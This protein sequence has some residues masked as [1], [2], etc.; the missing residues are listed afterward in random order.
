MRA[1]LLKVVRSVAGVALLASGMGVVGGL[2]IDL[3]TSGVA[4]ASGGPIDSYDLSCQAP[5]VGSLSLPVTIQDL[6]TAPA[7]VPQHTTY[8]AKPQLKVT[9]PGSLIKVA[10]EEHLTSI[11]VTAGTLTLQLLGFTTDHSVKATVSNVPL[12]VPV[13]ATTV[14]HG[15]A[16]TATFAT[17]PLTVTASVGTHAMARPANFTLTVLGLPI[18]C[19][20]PG[21]SPVTTTPATFPY[22]GTSTATPIV[23]I[24]ASGAPLKITTTSLPNGMQTTP[25]AQTVT[26]SGGATPYAWSA[27]GL[28]T[29]LSINPT[30]GQIHGTPTVD[31]TFTPVIKVTGHTGN[32][33]TKT[34]QLKITPAGLAIT[35]TSLPGG[36]ET[37]AY[38]ATVAAKGG[39]TPYAWSA[40][41]LPTGLTINA[42][43]GK[44]TGTPTESGT[45]TPVIKVTG[46]TATHVT[47]TLQI[48]IGPKLAITTT[49]LPNGTQTSAYAQSVTATGG[50]T[51]YSW[52]ATGLPTGLSINPTSGQIH[53]TPTV[54]GTF[55]PVI[56]VTG[57]TGNHVTKTLQLTITPAPLA[58]T[59]ASL[60]SGVQTIAYSA[61][62]TATGGTTPY[63]WS[64]T[65]LPTGLTIDATTGAITGTPT[66][67][68]TFTVT[69][70]V[71]GHTAMHVTKTLKLTVAPPLA[72]TTT[73]LPNGA[74]TAAYSATV[75]A[76]G[77]K[78]PYSWSA[79]GLPSGLSIGASTGKITGSPKAHGTFTVTVKVTGATATHVTKALK[80]KVTLAPLA[81]ATT[82]LPNGTVTSAY[83][84]TVTATGGT[85]P[86][87]W[88][89]TGL[90][91]GLSI[92][93]STGKITGT[94]TVAGTST[95]TVKVTGTTGN[96]VT[97]TLS[98][99]DRHSG[100]GRLRP[101]RLRRWG[102][103]LPRRAR[104]AGFFGSLPGAARRPGQ[105]R[106]SAWFPRSPTRATSSSGPT[107]GSSPSGQLRSWVRSRARGSPRPL[108]S[109]ASWPRTQ[110]RATSSWARTAGVFAFGTVPFLGSL[111]G[112][113]RRPTTSSGSPRRPRATATGWSR[114]QAPSTASAPRQA[115]GDSYGHVLAGRRPSL[116][117][118]QAAATG[119]PP[120]T[121]P[122]YP[123]GNAEVLRHTPGPPCDSRRC[124]SSASCT[125]RH[126]GLLAHRLGRRHL[127]LR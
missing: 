87:T 43:T 64:A 82:S 122:C 66:V 29:G 48:K 124:R 103:R 49:S 30:T 21:Q 58:I 116:G 11:T 71:T 74:E 22:T 106:S 104:A 90:P 61:T 69:I 107:A 78:T 109:P 28:P 100:R 20:S 45:F 55:T 98:L 111:P 85:T 97:K 96:H 63:T 56:K 62:V 75:T 67:H 17:V 14:K 123:F 73:S 32:H 68:G 42:T 12:V 110:T 83:S 76:S 114:P 99:T 34:L 23:S 44:I 60:P 108:P 126:K 35:T 15:Y 26:A 120:R 9:I 27:T 3:A 125:R 70:K 1:G 94:P 4:A 31:G 37:V 65:G 102:L 52:S 127:R 59:T 5:L 91:T 33:V 84:A 16:V 101:G 54:H 10:T 2:G 88:S 46:H 36:V 79:T 119:S 121:A 86:Y 39:T 112:R 118:P 77:G 72:I 80:L 57:H 40:T 95:V 50:E 18:P 115:P 113:G 53:G 13:N 7:S 24:Q 92:G 89:A 38:S 19:G 41:G 117:P 47:K 105:A 81:I 93:S 6:H 51:P 25:Y 8:D